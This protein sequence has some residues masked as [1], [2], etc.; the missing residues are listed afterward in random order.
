MCL[1]LKFIDFTIFDWLSTAYC[2]RHWGFIRGQKDNL[3]LSL[4]LTEDK[5]VSK[6]NNML[7]YLGG[8]VH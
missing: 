3:Y 8:A 2:S 5:I 4:V 6:R 7:G 1:S